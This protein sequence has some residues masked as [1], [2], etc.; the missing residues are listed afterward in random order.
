[1]HGQVVVA[2]GAGFGRGLAQH[3]VVGLHFVDYRCSLDRG[4]AGFWAPCRAVA[5]LRGQGGEPCG[6][7]G[8]FGAECC[9]AVGTLL[10]AHD[11]P[12][13]RLAG[14]RG[15][16]VALYAVVAGLGVGVLC[17]IGDGGDGELVF[18]RG[19]LLREGVGLCSAGVPPA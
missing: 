18:P 3:L 14:A 17:G 5:L 12:L 10:I 2:V 15:L 9:A 11:F 8:G 6:L 19:V 4:L 16:A 13:H 1:M 7:G